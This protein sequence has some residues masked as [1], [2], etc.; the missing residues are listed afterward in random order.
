MPV[1]LNNINSGV[2]RPAPVEE[3]QGWLSQAGNWL[4]ESVLEPMDVLWGAAAATLS[5]WDIPGETEWRNRMNQG[6]GW[7]QAGR[8]TYREDL[9][10][11][12]KV[13]GGL[14]NPLGYLPVAGWG[15]KAGQAIGG[16][17]RGAKLLGTAGKVA[18]ASTGLSRISP[19]L[20]T[21]VKA[22]TGAPFRVETAIGKGAE[23]LVRGGLN[24]TGV[25]GKSRAITTALDKRFVDRYMKK[26]EGLRPLEIKLPTV[27]GEMTHDA[28][29]KAISAKPNLG[30]ALVRELGYWRGIGKPIRTTS[31]IIN[32]RIFQD[33]LSRHIATEDL[34]FGHRGNN[35]VNLANKLQTR[36][37]IVNGKEVVEAVNWRKLF[38]LGS[39]PMTSP[40]AKENVLA[41]GVKLTPEG[42]AVNASRYI[43][44]VIEDYNKGWYALTPEQTAAIEKYHAEMDWWKAL[45]KEHNVNL[46]DF[47]D[48]EDNLHFYR[49]GTG[50]VDVETG[51]PVW[52]SGQGSPDKMRFYERQADGVANGVIY[53]ADPVAS[54]QATATWINK[55]IRDA[56]LD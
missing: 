33:E 40:L 39:E 4:T 18:E 54:A 20:G 45:A 36:E 42:E 47:E 55:K 49:L 21:A 3:N 41:R 31:N 2:T 44:D 6:T 48:V 29:Y 1:N 9:P 10:A 52:F 43:G 38:D 25:A 24:V 50:K 16:V 53:N 35:I 28:L 19:T 23:K 37:T 7:F 12:A 22:V 13:V 34:L 32:G 30:T 27:E 17:A 5:P 11:W 8:E 15:A 51:K 14:T 26:M 46:F 56:R